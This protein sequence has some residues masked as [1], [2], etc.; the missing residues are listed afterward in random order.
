MAI[1]VLIASSNGAVFTNINFQ[2]AYLSISVSTN[3]IYTI[4]VT[5]R[6]LF[7]RKQI[8]AALGEEHSK[9][10][11]SVAAMVVESSALY[12]AFG[13]LYVITF[14]LHNKVENLVFLWIIHVQVTI[15]LSCVL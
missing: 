13:V 9:I 6:L 7:M 14:A 2:L 15:I 3:F 12:S 10:Y 4:L 8:R 5:G 11:T 1:L